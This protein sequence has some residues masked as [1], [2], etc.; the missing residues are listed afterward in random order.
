M[1][2]QRKASFAIKNVGNNILALNFICSNLPFSVKEKIRLLMMSSIK[3][4][5]FNTMKIVNREIEL[6]T[7]KLDI[8]NKTRDDI[9]EQQRN[10]FLQQ[11]IKNLQAEMGNERLT[12]EER[13]VG[14]GSAEK[15]E[16]GCRAY[17]L[18]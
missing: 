16:R 17:L 1:I 18:S 5:L 14:K 10:Y 3:E 13:L 4:R 6:Q 12:R 11:Q 7:L 9:D 8:R 15:M 2:F